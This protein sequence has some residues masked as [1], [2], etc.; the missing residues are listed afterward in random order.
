MK[1]KMEKGL[2]AEFEG[3]M[4]KLW[5]EKDKYENLYKDLA[6]EHKEYKQ[7]TDE[8]LED[9]RDQLKRLQKEA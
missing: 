9:L 8:E 5:H 1:E 4:E 7:K 2:W 6:E 3:E